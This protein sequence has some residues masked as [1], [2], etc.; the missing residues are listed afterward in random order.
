MHTQEEMQKDKIKQELHQLE[1][2]YMIKYTK[3]RI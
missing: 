3:V 2:A 1:T